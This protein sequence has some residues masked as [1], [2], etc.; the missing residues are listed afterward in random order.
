MF[1]N[2][3]RRLAALSIIGIIGATITACGA[4]MMPTTAVNPTAAA[5]AVTITPSA[6]PSPTLAPTAVPAPEVDTATIDAFVQKMLDT[7]DV[8]GAAIALVL[9]DGR[10]YTQGYGVRDTTSGT[11]VSP[12][13]Q[14]AIASV[15]KSFT[16]LGMMM[17]VDEGKID[18]DAPVTTYLPAFRLSDPA[19]TPHVT[20]RHLLMHATGMER[21][22]AATGNPTITRDEIV[23]LAAETPLVAEPGE[24][25]VY[26][27]VNTI[28]AARIIEL[29]SGQSWE[30]FTRERILSP[31][32]MDTTTLDV[33]A[34]QQQSDH[35][36]PHEL[37]ML[38]GMAP[39]AFLEPAAE[40]PAGGVNASADEMLRYL[41][42]QL[43]DGTVDGTRLLSKE[44][45]AELHRTQ[46]RVDETSPGSGA[47]SV[48][49]ER[50]M[51]A[52]EDLVSD[53]GY[54]L[55]WFTEKLGD[56]QVVQ[57]DG[58]TVGFSA[59]VSLVP[60]ANVGVVVLTNASFAFGFVETVRIHI[61]EELLAIKPQ[62]DTHKI[63]EAQ[64]AVLGMDQQTVRQPMEAVR[65]FRVDPARLEALAGD[66]TN[67]VGE[68][69]VTVESVDGATLRLKA[70]L[71]GIDLVLDLLPYADDA[72]VVNSAPIRG[73]NAQ[74]SA[75]ADGDKIMLN[76]VPIAQRA[77]Q[78]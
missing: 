44:S 13:T 14:F 27:N 28:A 34:M 67:L 75:D 58:Q 32:N 56:H 43:G 47:S 42:F 77:A 23:A 2:I 68:G 24:K 62:H 53:F 63:V 5:P 12:D 26:S 7:Y 59:S 31:L 1:D 46:I 74:F 61:L 17:L 36:L 54:G 9:P 73:Y 37:D 64:L 15:T 40:A 72:F 18:L 65:N 33:A 70:Q 20:V 39:G 22:N 25:H 52:P 71:Q 69:A 50:G 30:D 21:N 3:I 76:G 55:Y 57:H 6:A 16:A 49:A 51:P 38:K 41:Q 4:S 60:E 78:P 45:L 66:Y 19:L 8:P 35:A 29:V 11:P 10:T 48:A